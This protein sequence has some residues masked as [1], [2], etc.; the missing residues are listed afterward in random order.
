M[1]IFWFGTQLEQAVRRMPKNCASAASSTTRPVFKVW[2]PGYVSSS[3]FIS[4]FFLFLFLLKLQHVCGYFLK[5][6]SAK[7]VPF[8]ILRSCPRCENMPNAHRYVF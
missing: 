7:V 8:A 2:P 3:I 5:E 6:F 4:I 1:F